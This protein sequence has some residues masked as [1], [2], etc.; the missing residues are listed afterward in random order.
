MEYFELVFI[1]QDYKEG[2]DHWPKVESENA[3]LLCAFKKK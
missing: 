2:F 3:G 1:Y